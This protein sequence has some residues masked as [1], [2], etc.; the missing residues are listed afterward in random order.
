MFFLALNKHQFEYFS[1]ISSFLDKGEVSYPRFNLMG[2]LCLSWNDLKNIPWMDLVSEKCREREVK[3][4]YSGLFYKALVFIELFL[5]YFSMKYKIEKNGFDSIVMWNGSHRYQRVLSCLYKNRI[6]LVYFENGLL[7]NTTTC[8]LLGVN[9]LNSVPRDKEYYLDLYNTGV[10]SD[11]RMVSNLIPRSTRKVF[12]QIEVPD[13][14]IFVPFQD[15]RDTQIRHFSPLFENMRELYKFISDEL[16]SNDNFFVIKEH[17][18]SRVDYSDLHYK[19]KNII[20][21]NG[22]STQELISNSSAVLTINSTVGLESILIGANVITC[23][24]AFYNIPEL[25]LHCSSK[26]ELKSVFIEGLRFKSNEKLR[27]SFLYYLNSIYCVPGDWK[28]PN[29]KH[30]EFIKERVL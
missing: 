8:D 16:V 2:L 28:K 11:Y 6:K 18:S 4:K 19:H 5:F 17:P 25:V 1:K 24:N 14:Y 29:I 7:P 3:N 23:G 21:A 22:N 15:D 20:F 10:V 13:N 27:N 26:H 12:E 9:Y 30:F